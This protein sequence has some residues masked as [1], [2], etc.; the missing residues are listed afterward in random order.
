MSLKENALEKLVAYRKAHRAWKDAPD[1][2]DAKADAKRERGKV[3]SELLEA[4]ELVE[5]LIKKS[6]R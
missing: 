3:H 5:P 4:A 2:S 1:K 6:E